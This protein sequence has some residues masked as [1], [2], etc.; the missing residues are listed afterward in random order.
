[1]ARRFDGKRIIVT[2]AGSGIG[3]A[4]A[5]AFA[6]EGGRVLVAD[7]KGDAAAAVAEEIEAAGGEVASAVVDVSRSPEVQ[8][9]VA[10]AVR[11]FGGLDVA[12][13]NA[14][15]DRNGLPLA[16]VEEDVF[17]RLVAVN[18]KGCFLSMKHEI[19]AMLAAGGGAIVNTS[20]IRGV[21][22]RPGLSP[23]AA[24]KHGVVGLTKSA[25]L[26]Y[27][28]SGIRINAICPGATDTPMF[29][30]WG[31]RPEMYERVISEIAARRV[32]APEEIARSV[33][34]M[35]SDDASFMTGHAMLVDGGQ[36][37]M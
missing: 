7:V 14:G 8:E 28:A 18:L 3:R 31:N 26:D 30:S 23:Y 15:I 13:N 6:M 21:L 5:I 19:P 1:M 9:M 2:G 32:A 36:S 34:F 20:S 16:E 24:S 11:L 12:F 22:G 17:D 25:A 33:L 4:A 35:A 27:A 10:K 37:A 29:R